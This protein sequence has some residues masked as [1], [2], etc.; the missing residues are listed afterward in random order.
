[1][2][3]I[4]GYISPCSPEQSDARI[5]F[6]TLTDSQKFLT[7]CATAFATLL[8][9]PFF[10]I[11]GLMSGAAAFRKVVEL[12]VE[13][14]LQTQAVN[15]FAINILNEGCPVVEPLYEN[16]FKSDPCCYWGMGSHLLDF[17]KS[18]I[19]NTESYTLDI[20]DHL[21]WGSL[22]EEQPGS[23]LM[24]KNGE[25]A[26]FAEDIEGKIAFTKRLDASPWI[27]RTIEDALAEFTDQLSNEIKAHP[28]QRP[29]KIMTHCVLQVPNRDQHSI[30]LIIEPD[31][32]IKN[33]A[34]ATIINNHGD[35]YKF[36]HNLEN[37][38]LEAVNKAYDHPETTTARNKHPTVT[39]PFCYMDC[40]ENIR[41]LASIPNV[42]KHIKQNKLISRTPHQILE[43]RKEHNTILAR[44]SVTFTALD[45]SHET[46]YHELAKERQE[47]IRKNREENP[48]AKYV[49]L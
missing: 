18:N 4:L 46:L 34:R 26:D 16:L 43:K 3:G 41:Y 17:S 30:P 47:K 8:G 29:S 11:G 12:F 27:N 37:Q 35:R 42:Q 31:P 22:M 14:N 40:I 45:E 28:N 33:K 20:T 24:E 23:W 39:G 1:M 10:G 15:D 6:A 25:A 44:M 9:L 5:E 32:I 38:I 2:Q 13:S 7:C 21:V 19:R 49:Y 36:Y 48:D